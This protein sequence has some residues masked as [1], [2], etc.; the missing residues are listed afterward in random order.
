MVYNDF[1]FNLESL[2]DSFR[3]FWSFFD[4]CED[5]RISRFSQNWFSRRL[6]SRFGAEKSKNDT[7]C[8]NYDNIF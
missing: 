1:G 2:S 4:A 5:A 7:Q 3:H 8:Q 6:K